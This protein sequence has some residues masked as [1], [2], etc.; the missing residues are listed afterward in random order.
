MKNQSFIFRFFSAT[1]LYWSLIALFAIGVAISP[2]SLKGSNIFLS[3]ENLSNVLRQVSNNGI[4]AVGMTLV[5]LTA[6]IDLSV[7]TMMAMGST[8]AAMLITLKGWSAASYFCV[9]AMGLAAFFLVASAV[10]RMAG[11][12]TGT[13]AGFGISAIFGAGACAASVLW[14]ASQ[15]P[16]GFSVV[17]VLVAVPVFTM[18]LGCGTGFV[19]A[20]GKLQPF[21][22][23][24]AMMIAVL[25]GA[26]L[27]AG[28]GHSVYPIYYGE[29]A[30]HSFE[31]LGKMLWGVIPV[32]GIFFLTCV[33][34]FW[35]VLNKTRFGRYIY[36]LGGNEQTAFLSGINVDRIKI[37]V[38]GISG[39]LAGLAGVLFAAQF[40]QGKPDAGSGNELD[41]IAAV[42]IGGTSLMGGRG[43]VIGT[44]VGVLIFG[45]LSNIL[46][47]QEVPT[48]WQL[49][50][51]GGIILIAVLLQEGRFQEG[52]KSLAQKFGISS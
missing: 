2:D 50:F 5:I 27:I 47:L 42:V 8:L 35:F 36:A 37:A 18:L 34:I 41:A 28:E 14:G 48:N 43:N 7:G 25:G 21:I 24:L 19:I 44:L 16:A 26:R 33:A 9:P 31:F 51:K 11:Q 39:F 1:K 22:V 30:P 29:N 49:V 13:T 12:R 23:T 32:P 52:I 38:Y 3:Q 45:L 17:G 10:S 4:L 46:V 6:G 20:K 40:E 15:T